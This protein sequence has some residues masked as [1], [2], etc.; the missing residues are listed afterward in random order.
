MAMGQREQQ[1]RDWRSGEHGRDRDRLGG[2]DGG[3]VGVVVVVVAVSA[4]DGEAR[5]GSWRRVHVV[6]RCCWLVLDGCLVGCFLKS[7]N[8]KK[9]QKKKK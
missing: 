7:E 8:G 4:S 3:N 9:K 5:R 6:G 2:L 1:W